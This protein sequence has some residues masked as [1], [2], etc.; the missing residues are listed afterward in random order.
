LLTLLV[1]AL[2]VSRFNPSF[3]RVGHPDHRAGDR[4]IH[5]ARAPLVWIGIGGIIASVSHSN[6]RI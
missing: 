4:R 2:V 3:I 1:E 5:A 6:S